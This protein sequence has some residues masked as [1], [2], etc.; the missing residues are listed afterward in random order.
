MQATKSLDEKLVEAIQER[1]GRSIKILNLSSIENA[2]V[3]SFIICQGTST[4][5]VAS[6]AD[7]VREYMQEKYGVKPFN[8]DGYKT[9]Q[10]I[11][12]DYGS[13]LVHVF[14]PEWRMLY[15]LEELWS[16]SDI[17]DIPDLD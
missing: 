14:T 10:W 17:T 7:S 9:S 12:L 16:D 15:N 3:G 6:I 13:S 5:H 1:K 11:V 2:G 4:T 8:Y